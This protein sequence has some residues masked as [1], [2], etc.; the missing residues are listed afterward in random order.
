MP[1]W[2]ILYL[3]ILSIVILI[4]LIKDYIDKRPFSYILG[5]FLSGAIGFTLVIAVWKQNLAGSLGWLVVPMLLYAIAWDQYALSKMRKSSYPDLTEEEN[6][7]MDRYSK[8]FAVLFVLPC[9]LAG[10]VLGY[11]LMMD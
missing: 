8:I 2:S 1:W 5:E 6:R 7:D 10:A 4:S 3:V 9:Y 11:R